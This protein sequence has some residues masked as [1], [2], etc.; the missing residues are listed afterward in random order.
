MKRAKIG[1]FEELVLLTVVALREE[2]YGLSVQ[3]AL[4]NEAKRPVELATVHSAL[5]RLEKKGYVRSVMG[6]ATKQRGGRRKR[7]FEVTAAGLQT[8]DEV[9]LIR[10]HMWSLIHRPTS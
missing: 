3:Q 5:Y 7:L 9:R 4:H 10:K 2:A 8:L 6:G 1:E